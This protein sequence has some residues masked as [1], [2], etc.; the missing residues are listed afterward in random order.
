MRGEALGMVETKGLVGA[1]E[2]ADAMVKAANVTLVG[3]EKIGSGL[4][5]VMVRGDVGAVKAA[6]DSGAAAAQR[7]G[8]LVSIHVIPRP[9]TDIEKILPK[10]E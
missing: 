10:G 1:I 9:H 2:A 6:T 7:V 3:Y 8:E 4:V 5:T